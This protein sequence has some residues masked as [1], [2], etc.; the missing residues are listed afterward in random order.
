MTHSSKSTEAISKWHSAGDGAVLIISST[1]FSSFHLPEVA[2]N[3]EDE[4]AGAGTTDLAAEAGAGG[5]PD[6]GN[7]PPAE[8]PPVAKPAAATQNTAPSGTNA[9]PTAKAADAALIN[10]KGAR[11]RPTGDFSMRS[12][13]PAEYN[14]IRAML[15]SGPDVVVAD[16]AHQMKNP[17]TQQY[18]AM[19]QVRIEV[20]HRG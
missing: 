16:E 20:K 4:A 18:K 1:F 5:I 9:A 2:D 11:G 7:G 15:M 3:P 14:E 6:D 13:R 8:P 10:K 19:M 17:S 12:Q